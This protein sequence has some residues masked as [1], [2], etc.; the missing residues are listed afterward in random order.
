[1]IWLGLADLPLNLEGKPEAV[2][3]TKYKKWGHYL[4]NYHSTW[5]TDI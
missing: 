4:A 3:I 2:V 5:T 1:V